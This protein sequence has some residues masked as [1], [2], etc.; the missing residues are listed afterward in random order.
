[1]PC[2][3]FNYGRNAIV[4]TDPLQSVEANPESLDFGPW[5]MVAQKGKRS[6]FL[7]DQNDNLDATGIVAQVVMNDKKKLLPTSNPAKV[8]FYVTN[9]APIFTVEPQ[10]KPLDPCVV[11]L[12][13][14]ERLSSPM[15]TFNAT[16][17][18]DS[19]PLNACE[20]VPP[21]G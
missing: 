11:P 9:T 20:D 6:R 17:E 8:L 14:S 19:I 3:N 5:M 10:P 15:L 12:C 13:G 18:N 7:K 2:N 21:L 1:M 16:F 4:L